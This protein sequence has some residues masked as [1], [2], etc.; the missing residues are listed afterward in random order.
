MKNEYILDKVFILCFYCYGNIRGRKNFYGPIFIC[1]IFKNFL[2]SSQ[3]YKMLFF[4]SNYNKLCVWPFCHFVVRNNIFML[5]NSSVLC[6]VMCWRICTK[7]IIFIIVTKHLK[8]VYWI[9]L[10]YLNNFILSLLVTVNFSVCFLGLLC[11]NLP[12]VFFSASNRWL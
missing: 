4:F 5:I 6:F 12:S 10:L 11:P 2:Y 3:F 7:S 8:C 1:S 9:T